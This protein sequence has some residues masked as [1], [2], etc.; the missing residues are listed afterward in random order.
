[1]QRVLGIHW[2]TSSIKKPSWIKKVKIFK[3]NWLKLELYQFDISEDPTYK[4][5][6]NTFNKID[7]SNYENC[8]CKFILNYCFNKISDW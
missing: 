4:S 2:M 5:W 1:M 8:L 6:G 7:F 3:E